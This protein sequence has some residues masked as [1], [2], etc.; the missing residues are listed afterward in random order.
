[1]DQRVDILAI[2][3]KFRTFIMNQFQ[4]GQDFFKFFPK[5]VKDDSSLRSSLLLKEMTFLD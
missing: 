1:M 2:F 3:W 5:V 4:V